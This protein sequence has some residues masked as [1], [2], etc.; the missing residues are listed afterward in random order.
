ME[1]C[2]W[3]SFDRTIAASTYNHYDADDD[4]GRNYD[5]VIF[6]ISVGLL[7]LLNAEP[8]FRFI[9]FS[10]WL[11]NFSYGL[12]LKQMVREIGKCRIIN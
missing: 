8:F 11:S 1:G 3:Y 4:E 10:N 5:N 2:N 7:G 12:W 9:P 6:S